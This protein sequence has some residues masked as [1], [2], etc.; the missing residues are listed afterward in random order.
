[1]IIF[2]IFL[3]LSIVPAYKLTLRWKTK[4]LACVAA[5]VGVVV[6]IVGTITASVLL[7]LSRN[8]CK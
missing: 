1:M 4:K 2:S 7:G 5:L 6:S 8:K 3:A